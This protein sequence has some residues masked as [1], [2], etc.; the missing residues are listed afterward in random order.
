MKILDL[1]K[2]TVIRTGSVRN[3]QSTI[4]GPGT[5]ERTGN[6][7]A[8]RDLDASCESTECGISPGRRWDTIGRKS[9]FILVSEEDQ[10]DRASTEAWRGQKRQLPASHQQGESLAPPAADQNNRA[11]VSDTNRLP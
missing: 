3:I 9:T 11:A 5:P 1:M 7:G 2:E 6:P 10:S 8:D 4:S